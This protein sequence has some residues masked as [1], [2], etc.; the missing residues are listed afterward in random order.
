MDLAKILITLK[1]HIS[2]LPTHLNITK[3]IIIIIRELFITVI[4]SINPHFPIKRRKNY[5]SKKHYH[6]LPQYTLHQPMNLHLHQVIE[7]Q[8]FQPSPLAP[9]TTKLI[10]NQKSNITESWN[11]HVNY[12]WYLDPVLCS[13]HYCRIWVM[14]IATKC[15]IYTVI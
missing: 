3:C 5:F 2:F 6:V 10:V 1:L 7:K 12:G 13:Y 11:T 14:E 9:M 8:L 15:I 4:N